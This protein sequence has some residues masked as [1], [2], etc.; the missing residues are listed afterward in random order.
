MNIEIEVNGTVI[1]D[2]VKYI[3]LTGGTDGDCGECDLSVCDHCN[4]L[5][6]S[7]VDREDD[8]SVIFKKVM[9]WN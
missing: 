7:S 8:N 4:S 3:C 6:C 9:K 1:I 2:A 5:M